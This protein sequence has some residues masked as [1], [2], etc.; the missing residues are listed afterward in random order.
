M[1]M[2]M[3]TWLLALAVFLILLLFSYIYSPLAVPEIDYAEF[4]FIEAPLVKNANL[5]IG[6][7]ESYLYTYTSVN[8]SGN[9]TFE[10]ENLGN[11]IYIASPDIRGTGVCLDRNGNDHTGSNVSMSDQNIFMFKPWM[12]AV[13][14]GWEWNVSV[15]VAANSDSRYVFD[16]EFRTL[17]TET[18]NGREAYVVEIKKGGVVSLYE[19]VDKERRILLKETGSGVTIEL[20]EEPGE[21]KR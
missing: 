19:W 8:E 18:V 16:V 11:C 13:D 7:G 14:E 1:A 5:S 6:G 4:E 20:V 10:T 21:A 15:Y 3:P 17:K 2:K 9:I 12:L